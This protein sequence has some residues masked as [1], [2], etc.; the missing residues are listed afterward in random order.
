[1]SPQRLMLI[2]NHW[3]ELVEANS[4]GFSSMAMMEQLVQQEQMVQQVH[5]GPKMSWVSKTVAQV[6][7]LNCPTEADGVHYERK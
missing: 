1:M 5:R 6:T 4:T 2:S 3:N 7:R